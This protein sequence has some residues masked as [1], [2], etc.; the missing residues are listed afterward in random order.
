MNT[1]PSALKDN[2]AMVGV[3][4][5]EAN[6]LRFLSEQGPRL[7][8]VHGIHRKAGPADK[9]RVVGQPLMW[10]KQGLG[11]VSPTSST[12]V[13][14]SIIDFWQ[15]GGGKDVGSPIE[16]I[17]AFVCISHRFPYGEEG[18]KRAF[19]GGTNT[20]FPLLLT[21][22]LYYTSCRITSITNKG[23]HIRQGKDKAVPIVGSSAYA[24]TTVKKA[25]S[26]PP[27]PY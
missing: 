24:G 1:P 6:W 12:L 14:G 16:T 20:S 18:K 7:P 13:T 2:K 26:L 23:I 4:H 21:L 17:R 19:S 11:N 27:Y 22:F 10:K 3:L 15:G 9:V 5:P 25:A 8:R